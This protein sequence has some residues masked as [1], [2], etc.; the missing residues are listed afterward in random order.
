MEA[1]VHPI[2]RSVFSSAQI[3]MVDRGYQIGV[4]LAAATFVALIVIGAIP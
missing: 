1:C 4:V 3:D 2:L